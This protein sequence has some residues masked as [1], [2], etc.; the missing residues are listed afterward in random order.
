MIDQLLA[1]RDSISYA[2]AITS[3]LL[4]MIVGYLFGHQSPEHLCA[5]YIVEAE[6]LTQAAHECNTQ[7]T[8]CESKQAG[9]AV[10]SCAPIC[11]KQ[12]AEALRNHTDI[13]CED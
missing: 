6:Q 2:I 5:E 10:L 3:I 12:V 8:Q 7:R 4:S 11:A 1:H 9:A 13:I